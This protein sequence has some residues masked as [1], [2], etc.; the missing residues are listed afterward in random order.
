MTEYSFY[1][2]IVKYLSV[3]I[4]KFVY[5]YYNFMYVFDNYTD[6]INTVI[7]IETMLR[8]KK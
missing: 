7:D 6:K 8:R 4:D 1:R 3:G 2:H 5:F